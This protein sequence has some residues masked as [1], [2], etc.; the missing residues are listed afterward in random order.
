MTRT[1]GWFTS[2]YPVAR[3]ARGAGWARRWRWVV[4]R[5][6]GVPGGGLG[7]GVLRYVAERGG[8]RRL[9]GRGRAP[10][11]FNYLGQFDQALGG[12]AWGAALFEAGA[13]SKGASRS[14][15]LR[16][17]HEL[18]VNAAVM[19]GRL[20]VTWDYSPA[21]HTPAEVAALAAG[22]A[23]ALRRIVEHCQGG[24]CGYTPSDFA[25][26]G[27]GQEELDAVVGG[28]RGVEDIYPLTPMQEGMLFHSLYEP[29]TGAYMRSNDLRLEGDF[30]V[31]AFGRAWGHALRRHAVLRTRFVWEGVR[32]PLQV[33]MREAALPLTVEDW[34]GLPEGEREERLELL[35]R[36]DR[37]RAFD[38][39]QAPLLRLAAVRVGEGSWRVVSSFSHL[40]ADGWSWPIVMRDVFRGYA[41]YAGGGEPEAEAAPVPY[42][43]Y[44]AWLAGRAEGEDERYW[45]GRLKDFRASTP[46][47]F[48][49]PE[50]SEPSVDED[51]AVQRV[52]RTKG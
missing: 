44:I 26:A 43:E 38:P 22:Y 48:D 47:P 11:S 40:L 39:A 13:E 5:L 10:V 15:R 37:A 31:E 1:V 9:R 46:L 7:Y 30:D 45:R 29:D 19:G 20:H 6:R 3:A 27:L 50:R 24:G 34:R 33:V 41:A 4:G 17:T 36:S 21:V 51:Y 32:R 2:S 28:V 12:G 35:V 25:L 49:R 16:R 8:G 18:E 23:A 14:G 52:E 42:R